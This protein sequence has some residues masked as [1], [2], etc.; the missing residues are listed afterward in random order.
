MDDEKQL[1]RQVIKSGDVDR[2]ENSVEAARGQDRN[3]RN[4]NIP[5]ED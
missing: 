5:Q 4:R 1:G 2:R 3:G